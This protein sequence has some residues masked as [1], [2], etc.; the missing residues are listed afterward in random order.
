MQASLAT[1]FPGQQWFKVQ[2]GKRNVE[3]APRDEITDHTSFRIVTGIKGAITDNWDYDVS[4]LKGRTISSSTYL[5]DFFRPA[6]EEAISVA[7][8]ADP[9]CLDYDVFTYMGVTPEMAAGLTAVGISNNETSIEVFSGII[10]GDTG[11]GFAAG[12]INVAAGYERREETFEDI[13]DYLYEEGL[14]MG[15]GGPRPSLIGSFDVSEL[16][17]EA[18]IPL[19][20]DMPFA[21]NLT[22]NLALRWSDH[23]ITGSDTTYRAGLDW[24][25]NDMLRVRTGFNRAVRSPNLEEFFEVEFVN[26]WYGNDPCAT[27]PYDPTSTPSWTA[28]Q[29][30]N[31]GVTPAQY[32]NLVNNPAGQ[33]NMMRGGNPNLQ[34]EEADTFTFGIV[35][36]PIEKLTMSLDYW[37]IEID[38][39]IDR[40]GSAL[41]LDMCGLEGRLCNYVV[42]APSGSLWQSKDGY[43]YDIMWN[44]GKQESAGLDFA[45]S[46]WLDALGG[47]WNINMI[48]TY[49][50]DKETTPLANDPSTAYDC[51]GKTDL[52]CYPTPKWRHTAA[53]TYD[54]HDWWSATARWRFFSSVDQAYADD[55]AG[56]IDAYNYLDLSGILKFGNDHDISIGINNV[57]DKEPPLVGASLS[58]QWANAN[59]VASFYDNLGRFLF[60]KVTFRF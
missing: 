42:R 33:L 21:K 49:M 58:G 55:V 14:L 52:S 5:N 41:I 36:D 54:S 28:A 56:D 17:G 43:V 20:A 44:L 11:V 2:I 24:K 37:K 13:R 29:C 35:V 38:K 53:V 8:A 15:Q 57:L 45:G 1:Y 31:T 22:M 23:N 25:T 40:I 59:T 60:A 7:C 30:A 19:L 16:F 12:N 50:L 6:V 4:Y 32:G 39:V 26:L 46:Y 48:G 9:D 34:P 3:G 51:V 10:K 18:S 47:T 27:D